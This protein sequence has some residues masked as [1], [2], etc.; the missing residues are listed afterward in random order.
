M[1]NSVEHLVEALD[2][3]LVLLENHKATVSN[4]PQRFGGAERDRHLQAVR[5]LIAE[6]SSDA[7]VQSRAPVEWSEVEAGSELR[8]L[9]FDYY[10]RLQVWSVREAVALAAGLDPKFAPLDDHG[11]VFDFVHSAVVGGQLT[12]PVSPPLFLDWMHRWG[13]MVDERLTAA[14][15][16]HETL[17]NRHA[18]AGP[19]ETTNERPSAVTSKLK[20]T[21]QLL[22]FFASKAGD[23]RLGGPRPDLEGLPSTLEKEM[24]RAGMKMSARTIR[25]RLRDAVRTVWT[26]YFSSR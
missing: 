23:I 5:R 20:S 19:T 17:Y 7:V 16:K 13:Y 24:D 15:R 14:V 10:A 6:F 18:S 25:D 3:A 22:V 26:D 8:Q 1:H 9:D 4:E 12:D 2:R 11:D 21:Q